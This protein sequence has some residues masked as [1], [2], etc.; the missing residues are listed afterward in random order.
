MLKVERLSNSADPDE[1]SPSWGGGVDERI[2]KGSL[3][4]N[5]LFT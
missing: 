5:I 2:S 4:K 3:L 1:T